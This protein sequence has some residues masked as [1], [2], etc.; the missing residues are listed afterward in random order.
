MS[1]KETKLCMWQKKKTTRKEIDMWKTELTE[2]EKQKKSNIFFRHKE[3]ANKTT[4]HRE[5][6]RKTE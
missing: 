2:I 6:S 5:E 3:M 4:S 1:K